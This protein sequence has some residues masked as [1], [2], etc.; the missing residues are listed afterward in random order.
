MQHMQ[1]DVKCH[2]HTALELRDLLLELGSN[3]TVFVTMEFV[4]RQFIVVIVDVSVTRLCAAES[5][6]APVSAAAA[7]L[8]TKMT[9]PRPRTHLTR[10]SR[11]P[12]SGH[13]HNTVTCRTHCWG[14]VATLTLN[15]CCFPSVLVGYHFTRVNKAVLTEC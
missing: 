14:R 15:L 12:T 13:T 9:S 10:R 8:K 4:G 2:R 5:A 11:R 7:L 6:R 1:T 3:I